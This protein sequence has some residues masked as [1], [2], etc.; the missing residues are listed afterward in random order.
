MARSF[1][2]CYCV[3]GNHTKIQAVIES[4]ITVFNRQVDKYLLPGL[5]PQSTVQVL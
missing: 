4:K 5:P 1:Y 3:L 2:P